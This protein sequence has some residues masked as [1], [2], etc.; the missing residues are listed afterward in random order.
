MAALTHVYINVFLKVNIS[1]GWPL[2]CY[3]EI[4]KSLKYELML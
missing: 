4:M 2:F 3:R 1:Q